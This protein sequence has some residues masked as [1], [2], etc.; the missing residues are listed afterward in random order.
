[1]GFSSHAL[2]SRSKSRCELAW[3]VMIY[4]IFISFEIYGH[5]TQSFE[6]GA[7]SMQTDLVSLL[8]TVSVHVELLATYV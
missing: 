5:T 3:R 2:Y 6:A 1:M 7:L 4:C 8:L